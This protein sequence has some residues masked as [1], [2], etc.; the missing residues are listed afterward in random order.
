MTTRDRAEVTTLALEHLRRIVQALHEDAVAISEATGL[1]APQFWAL[2]EVVRADDD[3]LTLSELARRLALHKANAGRLVERLARQRLVR[4]E[5]PADDRRVVIVRPTAAGVRRC[6]LPIPAPPQERL[7]ARLE[8]LSAAKRDELVRA[9]ERL[10]ELLGAEAL[11]PAPLFE[12][13]PARARGRRGTR[14]V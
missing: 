7:R 10:V 9:L 4:R 12:Q 1:S 5:T 6:Q 13:P 11:E 3:G 2:R 8:R 14:R